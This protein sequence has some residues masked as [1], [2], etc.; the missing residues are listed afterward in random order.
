MPQPS[1]A[2]R[3]GERPDDPGGSHGPRQRR[4]ARDG[5]NRRPTRNRN[6]IQDVGTDDG[7]RQIGRRAS[8]HAAALAFAVTYLWASFAGVGGAIALQRAAI[9][10]LLTFAA[11]LLL[12]RPVVDT[13]LDALARDEA[14]RQ[15]QDGKERGA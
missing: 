6:S 9:T 5:L 2:A 11:T 4:P 12:F 10:A 13:V 3:P 8:A 1:A 7:S 14:R 15:A